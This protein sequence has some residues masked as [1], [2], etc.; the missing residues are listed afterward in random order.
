MQNLNSNFNKDGIMFTL[1]GGV[2][3]TGVTLPNGDTNTGNPS[4][5][6]QQCSTVPSEPGLGSGVCMTIQG[7][8]A[9]VHKDQIQMETSNLAD[10]SITSP[11]FIRSK[12]KSR[13]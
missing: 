12:S 13:I 8:K 7:F 1:P 6:L 3:G 4:G 5:Y 10:N 9:A 2:Q 11:I